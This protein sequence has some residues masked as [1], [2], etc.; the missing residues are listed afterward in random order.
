MT[1]LQML[2]RK[3]NLDLLDWDHY[4]IIRS[5]SY[6]ADGGHAEIVLETTGDEFEYLEGIAKFLEF[7]GWE[8][9]TNTGVGDR[10]INVELKLPKNT[11]VVDTP[12]SETGDYDKEEENA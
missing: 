9:F 4:N 10:F 8:V 5:L 12:Y 6:T 1:I 2:Y 7:K 3:L 11:V